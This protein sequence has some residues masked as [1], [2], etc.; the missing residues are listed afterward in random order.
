MNSSGTSALNGVAT[1]NNSGA[2]DLFEVSGGDLVVNAG[3]IANAG[4][5]EVKGTATLELQGLT[6]TNT[7]GGVH[8]SVTVD[9]GGILDLESAIIGAGT[10]AVSGTLNSSGTSALNGVATT[11]NS[12]AGD[13]FEVSGGDLVVNAGSIANAGS[14]EVKGTAT[15]E[16]QG[17][18]LTNTVGGVHGS[19]TV[20][21]GGI[22]DLESAIIAPARLRY[23]GR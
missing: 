8:G 17:L 23:Q 20:D 13:L 1:T 11:N 3:S 9:S 15:L 4:S 16:L 6:L 12:G 14:I 19:V 22:L 18:T 5:I 21:S 10:L 2:G 7:V